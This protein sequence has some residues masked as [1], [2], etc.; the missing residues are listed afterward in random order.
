MDSKQNYG[1]LCLFQFLATCARLSRILSFRVHIK[2]FYRIVSYVLAMTLLHSCWPLPS[3]PT[4]QWMACPGH[5]GRSPYTLLELLWSQPFASMG[6]AGTLSRRICI[7]IRSLH[8]NPVTSPI[9]MQSSWL[10]IVHSGDWCLRLALRTP[11]GACHTRRRR[12]RRSGLHS[13]QSSIV[14]NTLENN[15]STQNK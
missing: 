10:R 2:L 15:C 12:K 11:S 7:C 3:P 8:G 13:V 14:I 9:M 1:A 4:R 6:L 5:G